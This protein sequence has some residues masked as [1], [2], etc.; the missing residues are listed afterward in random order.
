MK[1]R[2]IRGGDEQDAY[3]AWRKLY[4]YLGRAGAVK[5]VKKRT[6]RRE[7]REGKQEIREQ[8]EDG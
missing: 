7:R 2:I 4:I 3:T 1:K 8:L 5:K 6:H